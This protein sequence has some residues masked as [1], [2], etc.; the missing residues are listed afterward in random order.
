MTTL[1]FPGQGSQF[2]GMAKDFYDNFKVAKYIFNL[3]ED[4]TEIKVKEIV[5]EN[6]DELLDITKYTQLCTY[7]ASMAIYE[8]FYE[9]FKNTSIFNINYVL[10]HSLGEYTALTI[11]KFIKIQDCA[12]LLKIRGELMQ[13]AYPE[14]KSGMAAVIGLD[15]YTIEKIIEKNLVNIEIAN[16]NTPTQVV[17]SGIM[18][19]LKKSE[20]ILIKYGA[21]KIVYLNV[22]S[23]FHSRIM[24]K[25]EEK[26][27]NSLSEINFSNPIYS[28]I[29]NYSATSSKDK[30]IIFLNLSKQMSNKVKWV[31]SIKLLES[32]NEKNIIEIGP[33]KVL[34]GIIK[35]ISKNFKHFNINEVSD[36]DLLKNAI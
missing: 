5:F 2:V 35:R 4:C 34:T 18:D 9:I 12:R 7:T 30:S 22:S 14:N 28:V 20:E 16:D 32:K 8:V 10:G 1:V 17:I 36:I 26:M 31:D 6:K 33:G 23:A 15:C 11:S 24:K 19:N 3:V 13:E 21:K 27:K 25:A 29:S